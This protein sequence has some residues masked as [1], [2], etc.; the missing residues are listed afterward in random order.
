MSCKQMSMTLTKLK[1]IFEEKK[2]GIDEVKLYYEMR[3]KKLIRGSQSLD[4]I[5]TIIAM[6]ECHIPITTHTFTWLTG[7]SY[8]HSIATLHLLGDKNVLVWKRNLDKIPSSGEPFEWIISPFMADLM[9]FIHK[10]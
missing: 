3:K 6:T 1:E 7:K 9:A 4:N 2:R 10:E 8:G 5:K